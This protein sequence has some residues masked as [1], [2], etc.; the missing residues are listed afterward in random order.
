MPFPLREPSTTYKYF[1][2][3]SSYATSTTY[4]PA[5]L[6]SYHRL[7]VFINTD[8]KIQSGTLF[9]FSLLAADTDKYKQTPHH[10]LPEPGHQN[11]KMAST[12]TTAEHPAKR[13]KLD[14]TKALIDAQRALVD[15][16]RLKT[17]ESKILLKDLPADEFLRWALLNVPKSDSHLLFVERWLCSEDPRWL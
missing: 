5:I 16:Q 2:L 14:A 1:H 6:S 15:A 8:I 7:G 11:K 12:D 13:Q 4:T 10:I 3:A 9:T 17:G